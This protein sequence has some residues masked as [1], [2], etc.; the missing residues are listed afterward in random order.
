MS[1]HELISRQIPQLKNYGDCFDVFSNNPKHFGS[2]IISEKMLKPIPLK[3]KSTLP[4]YYENLRLKLI[5]I[6]P[7]FLENIVINRSDEFLPFVLSCGDNEMT[8]YINNT[9]DIYADKRLALIT[10]LRDE[11]VIKFMCNHTTFLEKNRKF[12]GLV[13]ILE[14]TNTMYAQRFLKF[15]IV[16]KPDRP[17][18]RTT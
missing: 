10:P 16:E 8:E 13:I 1:T 17:L 18:K 3:V 15:R 7:M 14:D 4:P 6:D 9:T 2:E 11:I 5:V 12:V